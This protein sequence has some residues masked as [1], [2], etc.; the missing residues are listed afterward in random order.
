MPVNNSMSPA[1]IARNLK[2]SRFLKRVDVIAYVEDKEDITFWQQTISH[3]RPGVKVSFIPGDCTGDRVHTGKTI[4]LRY[5][6]YLD[7]HFIICVDSDFDHFLNPGKLSADKYILQTHTYSWENHYCH[8]PELQQ[9]WS[10][11]SSSIFD[12]SEFISELNS[13][14][15]PV[16]TSMLAAK[17]QR[18]SQWNLDSLC[19][20]ILKTQPNTHELIADNGRKLLETIK[21]NVD[22]WASRQPSVTE[23]DAMQNEASSVGLTPNTAY[24]YMQG[25]CVYDLI[26][27]IG[28]FL[29]NGKMDFRYQ[30]MQNSLSFEGYPQADAIAADIKKII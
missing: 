13:I 2:S 28:N 18:L 10:S 26:H 30:V 6:P 12:F 4:C 25:H 17:R 5:V 1:A 7:R 9:T 16:L 24:L 19:S 22:A 8:I 14:L 20:E 23:V 29:T 21:T 27:R 15:Y 11:L 3:S